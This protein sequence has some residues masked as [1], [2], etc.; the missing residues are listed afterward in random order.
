MNFSLDEKHL[1]GNWNFPTTIRF[2]AGRAKEVGT[3]CQRLNIAKPLLV[4][5]KVLASL[6]L[7]LDLIKSLE[8][9]D[10]DCQ[11]FSDIKPNP[12]GTNVAN[13]VAYYKS[14]GCD[15]V[16]CVGGGS[17]LDAGKSIALMSGQ[18]QDLF[19][20]EDKGDNWTRVNE[21]GVAPLIALPTTSGTGSEV[22]RAAVIIDESCA[23][24]KIIFH[25]KMMPELVICDPEL[26]R[27]LP[28]HITAATGIDAL[29]H[30]LEAFCAPGFH[31]LA[32]GIA[33]EGIRL[34]AQ[35]IERAYQNGDDMQ[36]R[37]YLMVASSMGATAFQKG[38]GGVH[39]LAHPL[40]A[41][42]DK[43]HGLLNAIILPYVLKFN[44]Q[45]IETKM[46]YLAT[47]LGLESPSFDTMFNFIVDLLLR[48]E[49]PKSL[50]DIGIDEKEAERIGLLAFEDSCT[51]TNPCDIA[52]SDY[53]NIFLKACRGQ[54]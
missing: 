5:D 31:P 2:G 34:I 42:F 13:G 23:T 51:Q 29:V 27:G 49:I 41:L 22:G 46:T 16:I 35:Y 11:L 9:S 14:Q 17:A 4:T 15:G 8:N 12:T 18:T 6:P 50:N 20:F 25:P 52:A 54:L 32:D 39:A 24:K 33:V 37:A 44:Q 36:A 21:S 30:N 48:L 38:L 19:A 26:T 40:G 47:C 43:H 3:V 28:A 1:N 7:V 53:E 10:L 45:S